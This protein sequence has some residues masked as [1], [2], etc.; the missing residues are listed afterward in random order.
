M[1]DRPKATEG[2]N[3]LR[4]THKRVRT[5]LIWVFVISLFVNLL[6]FTQPLYLFQVL[7]RVIGSAS[8]ST[9]LYL[10]LLAGFAFLVFAVLSEARGRLLARLAVWV[11]QQLGPPLLRSSMVTTVLGKSVGMQGFRDLANLRNFLQS[12]TLVALID[13]P[14]VP[15]FIFVLFLMHPWLGSTALVGAALLLGVGL[16]NQRLSDNHVRAAGASYSDAE[17]QAVQQITNAEVTLA[18]GMDPALT[19]RWERQHD[20]ALEAQSKAVNTSGILLSAS[21]FVRMFIQAGMIGVGAY[22]LLKGQ[23]T[24]GA[25]I[26]ASILAGRALSPVEQVIGGWRHLISARASLVVVDKLLSIQPRQK[27]AVTL[28]PPR[29]ELLVEGV[30]YQ[31]ADCEKPVISNISFA[32]EPGDL[33]ALVGRSSAGKST[34]CRLIVGVLQPDRGH[35]RLDGA[36]L[37]EWQSAGIGEHIGYLPQSVA[38]FNG[39]VAENIARMGH[40]DSEQVIAAAKLTGLHDT[41]LRLPGGYEYEI[42]DYGQKISGGLRQRLGLARAIYGTPK[43][44]VLDEPN[45]NLDSAGERG[46]IQALQHLRSAGSTIVVVSHTAKILSDCNRVVVLDEGALKQFGDASE[47]LRLAKPNPKNTATNVAG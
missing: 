34:L 29:G 18:M 40:P 1:I 23:L 27:P 20:H 21:K 11:S 42:G 9:L 7:D 38:L 28:P 24:A 12:G 43:L 15:I 10:T 6:L 32:L 33:C 19:R 17:G 16:L 47:V 35:I 39:T 26:A 31:P 46:L 8:L 30:T 13:A 41:I 25:M 3:V 22:L 37:Y 4:H 5:E 36:D 14:S 2:Q 45:S 44:L